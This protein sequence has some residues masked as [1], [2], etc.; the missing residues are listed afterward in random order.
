MLAVV[1]TGH[2]LFGEGCAC[3]SCDP[4][5]GERNDKKRMWMGVAMEDAG[6]PYRQDA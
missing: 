4:H 6:L 3:I 5:V 2:V 1:L